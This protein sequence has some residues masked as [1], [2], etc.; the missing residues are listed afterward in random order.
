MC[1]GYAHEAMTALHRLE[2]HDFTAS[3][4]YYRL[5]LITGRD[6]CGEI[7]QVSLNFL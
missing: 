1:E 4:P 6:F 5:P 7:V 3:K 2:E